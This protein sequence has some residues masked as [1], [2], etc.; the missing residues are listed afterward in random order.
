[1]ESLNKIKKEKHQRLHSFPPLRFNKFQMKLENTG[2]HILI[3]AN[4][5]SK[6]NHA[7]RVQNG[8][9]HLKIKKPKNNYDYYGGSMS[10][11]GYEKDIDFQIRLPDKQ[12][13]HIH[14]VRFYHGV[15]KIHLSKEHKT[16]STV[17]LPKPSFTSNRSTVN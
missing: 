11:E 8:V 9:L 16:N 10:Y 7:V 1:M 5:L 17:R 2:I 3:S 13:C 15:L 14:T 12:H 6:Y 4:F